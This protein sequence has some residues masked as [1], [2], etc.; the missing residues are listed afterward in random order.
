MTSILWGL[1]F[2]RTDLAPAR[3]DKALSGHRLQPLAVLA[4]L[5]AHG[6]KIHAL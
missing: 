5:A 4:P 1:A 2:T 6:V 3:E